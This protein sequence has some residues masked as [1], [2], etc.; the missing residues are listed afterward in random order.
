MKIANLLADHDP[1]WAVRK[2]P[3]GDC[4]LFEVQIAS[5]YPLDDEMMDKLCGMIQAE[6]DGPLI[7]FRFS[8]IG[9]GR[10]VWGGRVY[11]QRLVQKD[12]PS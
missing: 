10:D 12:M 4:Q 9:A 3:R 7:G 1:S 11:R 6:M 2:V 8:L 5:G